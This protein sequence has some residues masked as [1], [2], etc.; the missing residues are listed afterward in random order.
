MIYVLTMEETTIFGIGAICSLFR[1]PLHAAAVSQL[2]FMFVTFVYNHA[3]RILY[4]NVQIIFY[5]WQLQ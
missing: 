4:N 5:A 2:I 3:F 1:L